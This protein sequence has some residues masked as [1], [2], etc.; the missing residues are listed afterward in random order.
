MDRQVVADIFVAQGVSRMSNRLRTGCPEGQRLAGIQ[1]GGLARGTV[2]CKSCIS[3]RCSPFT[4]EV[5]FY[6][7]RYWA[8]RG[9]L[10]TLTR[11]GETS[12]WMISVFDT[13]WAA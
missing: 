1:Q 2:R 13:V 10:A 7:L 6:A 8:M 12:V 5:V 11:V 3:W 9:G 4:E